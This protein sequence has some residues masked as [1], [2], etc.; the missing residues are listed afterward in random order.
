MSIARDHSK[1]KRYAA[2]LVGGLL[3]LLVVQVVFAGVWPRAA[4]GG[5]V[6]NFGML[7]P[8]PNTAFSPAN[9]RVLRVMASGSALLI[10]GP[11]LVVFPRRLWV[12]LF[13]L[14][15]PWGIMAGFGMMS[16]NFPGGLLARLFNAGAFITLG[17]IEWAICVSIC[18]LLR[19]LPFFR[20]FTNDPQTGILTL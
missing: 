16:P 12:S 4:S 15:V 18:G 17:L 9:T 20:Q 7:M 13:G 19:R 10:L 2:C 14:A 8:L 6:R 1:A 3:C 5:W 11:A